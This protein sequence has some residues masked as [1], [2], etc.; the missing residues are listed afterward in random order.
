M[1][2]VRLNGGLGNQLFQYAFA[3]SNSI[4]TGIEYSLDLSYLNKSS[5]ARNYELDFF[6]M[7]SVNVKSKFYYCK[8][9]ILSRESII[10]EKVHSHQSSLMNIRPGQYI[11]GYFQSEKYFQHNRSALLIDLQ[12]DLSRI[13][14]DTHSLS[15]KI[16]KNIAVSIHVRRGDYATNEDTLKFH[17]LCPM[18]YYY[19]AQKIMRQKYVSPVF[20]IFSDDPEWCKQQF[21]SSV[22]THIISNK[23]RILHEEF[24]LMTQCT[25]HIIAN[26]TFS[27]WAAWLNQNESKTVIAPKN[28]FHNTEISSIDI[29]PEKWMSI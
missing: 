22:D 15:L 8:K 3:R 11:T 1:F 13:S 14:T 23:S 5:P 9:R 20:Y 10:T 26:S 19:S 12:F 17:G 27:W 18:D 24:Y 21:I 29:I 4:D 2:I 7:H 28:W 6:N 16:K 25:H